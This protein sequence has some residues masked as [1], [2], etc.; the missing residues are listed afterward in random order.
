ME[1]LFSLAAEEPANTLIILLSFPPHPFQLCH[2]HLVKWFLDS[3]GHAGLNSMLDGFPDKSGYAQTVVAYTTGPDQIV[4]VFDGRTEGTIVQPRGSLDFGWD[5]IFE[6]SRAEE[7]PGRL[8]YA[9]MKKS[10]KNE[11]SHRSKA[12][13]QLKVFLEKL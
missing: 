10:D 11:I 12:F 7:N 4:H 6:P 13:R 2:H 3:C 8:T 9:E 5:P 1:W